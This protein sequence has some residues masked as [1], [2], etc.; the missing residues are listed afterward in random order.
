[1]FNPEVPNTFFTLL[2]FSWESELR[3]S[4]LCSEA[5]ISNDNLVIKKTFTILL[6]GDV[7]KEK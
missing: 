7:K 4:Y 1:M 6:F 3:V 5:A 2:T